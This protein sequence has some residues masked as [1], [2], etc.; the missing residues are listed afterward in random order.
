MSLMP[1]DVEIQA[2]SLPA[3]TSKALRRLEQVLDYSADLTPKEIKEIAFGLLDRSTGAGPH[4]PGHG[5]SELSES[6]RGAVLG[7]L[8]GLATMF[9]ARFDRDSTEERLRS[10][11]PEP[12]QAPSVDWEAS[13]SSASS[14]KRG[15]KALSPPSPAGEEQG[16]KEFDPYDRL[17]PE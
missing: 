6:T 16:E 1:N 15:K 5:P 10:V 13:G 4:S 14:K 9:G 11:S 17:V 3:L 12:P 8:E 2:P 7:A